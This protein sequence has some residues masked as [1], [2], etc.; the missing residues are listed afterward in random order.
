MGSKYQGRATGVP[1]NQQETSFRALREM[2]E[3]VAARVASL[4]RRKA[5]DMG[6]GEFY[7]E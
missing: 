7:F 2:V 5:S 1:G 6:L 4:E 3:G